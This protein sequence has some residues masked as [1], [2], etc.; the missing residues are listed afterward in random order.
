MNWKPLP[1]ILLKSILSL[2]MN[3]TTSTAML[4]SSSKTFAQNLIPSHGTDGLKQGR[5]LGCCAEVMLSA[6]EIMPVLS[7]RN[8]GGVSLW[9]FPVSKADC[10]SVPVP[11]NAL[12]RWFGFFFLCG[13]Q[14]LWFR[15]IVEEA[16]N[17]EEIIAAVWR[18]ASSIEPQ[19]AQFSPLDTCKFPKMFHLL[20]EVTRSL[21]GMAKLL[22]CCGKHLRWHCPPDD[23]QI[24]TQTLFWRG[25]T[26]QF[27][28]L[29]KSRYSLHTA[30][31]SVS[32]ASASVNS[33]TEIYPNL[34]KLE[35]KTEERLNPQD[36]T[37]ILCLLYN[38]TIPIKPQ[39]HKA[40]NMQKPESSLPH[41]TALI[42]WH[43]RSVFPPQLHP[44]LL[45]GSS[46][47]G[48]QECCQDTGDSLRKT[49]GL[50]S[51]QSE[52]HLRTTTPSLNQHLEVQ[53]LVS[54]ELFKSH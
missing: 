6:T 9:H 35:S 14:K 53:S 52:K 26:T 50:N 33:S 37:T 39:I 1:Q 51:S 17:M 47:A 28:Y 48:P 4:I 49:V 32:K 38:P 40:A 16:V 45:G 21:Q 29:P 13:H 11:D 22:S 43:L 25:N 30:V 27:E 19:L 18:A 12:C 15:W 46:P 36:P 10:G 3:L 24:R 42:T 5:T 41:N 20:P 44:L 2:W 34:E 8:T 31:F 54:G 23:T 7:S